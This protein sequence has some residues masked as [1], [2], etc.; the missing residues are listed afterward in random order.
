MAAS[1]ISY[2]SAAMNGLI[3]PN[4]RET[5]WWF[6]YGADSHYGLQTATLSAGSGTTDMLVMAVIS[7]LDSETTYHYRIVASNSVGASYGN[8]ESFITPAQIPDIKANGSDGPVIVSSGTPVSVTVSL[9]PGDYA[10]YNADWWVAVSTPFAPP[11]DWYTYV[12]P[13]GWWPGINLCIQTPLFALSPPF[14]VLYMTLPVGNYTFY[15]AVDYPDG[16][17]TAEFLDSLEVEVR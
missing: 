4:G 14:E 12:Y 2:D 11:G 8:D 13:T 16:I 17:V 5:V 10:G 15:F 3:N 6:E 9:D 7:G 1:S